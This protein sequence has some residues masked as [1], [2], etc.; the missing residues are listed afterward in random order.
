M[1]LLLIYSVLT[2]RS[3]FEHVVNRARRGLPEI[4]AARWIA[5]NLPSDARI[6]YD[7]SILKARAFGGHKTMISVYRAMAFN[8]YPRPVIL[9]ADERDLADVDYFYTRAQEK[10]PTVALIL[11][12]RVYHQIWSSKDYTL[13][14]VDRD[15]AAA[16]RAN[17]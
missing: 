14:R 11:W 9:V 17:R 10:R 8:T 13:H 15:A 3:G 6:G 2:C 4:E 16:L 7:T 12:R 5:A 1:A